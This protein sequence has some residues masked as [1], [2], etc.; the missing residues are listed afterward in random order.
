MPDAFGVALSIV[1][2]CGGFLMACQISIIRRYN[3]L[4]AKSAIREQK[5]AKLGRHSCWI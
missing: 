2:L 3:V 4:L 5:N 1:I